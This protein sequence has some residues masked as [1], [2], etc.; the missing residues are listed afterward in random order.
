MLK[1]DQEQVKLFEELLSKFESES[2][3]LVPQL[4]D[5]FDGF[6]NRKIGKKDFQKIFYFLNFV[7]VV[8]DDFKGSFLYKEVL[9][10]YWYNLEFSKIP[11]SDMHNILFFLVKDQERDNF[12]KW[13]ILHFLKLI[14]K[15]AYVDLKHDLKLYYSEFE[16][17]EYFFKR[18]N[19]IITTFNLENNHIENIEVDED[20]VDHWEK[21]Y[22]RI[23]ENKP[24]F[25]KS[26]FKKSK[27][28]LQY[29]LL[30]FVPRDHYF[31]DLLP[32]ETNYDEDDHVTPS[33]TLLFFI[34][35][36]YSNF[37]RNII[38]SDIFDYQDWM[39]KLKIEI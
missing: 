27:M 13:D 18:H 12:K 30:N 6:A 11:L 28:L 34:Q 38:V 24:F 10:L 36:F 7:N 37:K 21:E 15:K 32:F 22:V 9:E 4:K 2:K 16:S 39:T 5:L 1:W 26:F 19:A 35:L 23:L 20:Y 8:P 25:R 33:D 31:H 3:F 29:R 17:L 14:N